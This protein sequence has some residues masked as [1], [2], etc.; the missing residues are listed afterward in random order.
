MESINLHIKNMVCPRCILVVEEELKRMG[1]QILSIELGYVTIRT[2]NKPTFEEINE[3]LQK[4]GFE[5]LE[6]KTEVMLEQIKLT[7]SEY[8]AKLES[9]ENDN[10]LSD[11]L[12]KELGKN[13]NFLS[14]LFSKLE[15]QTI[16]SYFIEKRIDRVKEL[17]D[18]D[19][20]SLSEIAVNLGYSSVHYLSA[21]FKKVTGC[22]VTDYKKQIAQLH[23]KYTSISSA[24]NDLKK[25]GYIYDFDRKDN[26]YEC[27]ELG[28]VFHENDIEIKEVYRFKETISR[29]GRS[30]IYSV[31]SNNGIKGLLVQSKPD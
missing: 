24:I 27:L 26:W 4:F 11:Y 5:L 7:I 15:I 9:H 25:Q 18:Y 19:E 1:A 14:K 12:S 31:D 17:L 6:D 2:E 29:N 23:S 8:L 22:S 3:R 10:T 13:Y 28:S 20:K 30:V 16:E 21:Q